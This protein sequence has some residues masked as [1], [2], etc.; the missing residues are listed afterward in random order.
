VDSSKH[1]ELPALRPERVNIIPRVSDGFDLVVTS[2]PYG[3]NRTTVPYGQHAYLPLQW[4]DFA[5][6]DPAVSKDCLNSTHEIDNRSLGGKL[7]SVTAK[8]Q[9][10]YSRLSSAF[11]TDIQAL[12]RIKPKEAKKV[13]CFVRDLSAVLEHCAQVVKTNG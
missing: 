3:N 13:V 10:V 11:N 8:D 9:E 4:I 2:P 7:Q 1:I 5:D 12:L 6:I